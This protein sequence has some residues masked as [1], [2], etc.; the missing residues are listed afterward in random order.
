MQL[1]RLSPLSVSVLIEKNELESKGYHLDTL[2]YNSESFRN[3]VR[4]IRVAAKPF[5]KIDNIPSDAEYW[6]VTAIPLA[7]G[8]L[9]VNLTCN[10]SKRKSAPIKFSPEDFIYTDNRY[11]QKPKRDRAGSDGFICVFN[12]INDIVAYAKSAAK[13]CS[14]DDVISILYQGDNNTYKLY[15]NVDPKAKKKIDGINVN[16]SDPDYATDKTNAF[17]FLSL[18]YGTPIFM[19]DEPTT[20]TK[21]M[22]EEKV[23]IGS[24]ALS[25]LEKLTL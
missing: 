16:D 9:K 2:T 23:L 14:F 18:E 3:L 22:T 21:I 7:N 13:I 20:T 5:I 24:D 11:S 15:I 19:I 25:K 17:M 8:S 6:T 10:A 12:S 4:D 1:T